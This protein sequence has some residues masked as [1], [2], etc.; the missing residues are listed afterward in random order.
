M[1]KYVLAILLLIAFAGIS[2]Q[3]QDKEIG[4]IYIAT[5]DPGNAP[6]TGAPWVPYTGS[7]INVNSGSSIWIGVENL[8]VLEARKNLKV[9][10]TGSALVDLDFD[11]TIGYDAS[12]VS[13]GITATL[14]GAPYI[15][16][17]LAVYNFTYV[18]QPEWETI[19]FT[20]SGSVSISGIVVVSSCRVPSLT[21]W[22][23]IALVLILIASSIF[24][25]YRRRKAVTA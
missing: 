2:A 11:A 6:L 18:P 22:G 19:K 9:T 13:T 10:L 23:I 16:A 17:S 8:Y 3:A 24:V 12:G 5:T 4:D 20:S 14:L 25:V 15:E 7:T 21:Q 1:R